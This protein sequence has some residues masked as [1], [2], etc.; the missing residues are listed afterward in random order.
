MRRAALLIPAVLAL[1]ACAVRPES[2][3]RTVPAPTPVRSKA[4]APAPGEVDCR[5][6]Q[7]TEVSSPAFGLLVFALESAPDPD[8]AAAAHD[9]MVAHFATFDDPSTA[10]LVEIPLAT[11]RIR[12]QLAYP[13]I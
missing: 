6:I 9:V 5:A 10:D 1:T 8:V 4:V 2:A 3:P 13:G 7:T 11:L 12:C